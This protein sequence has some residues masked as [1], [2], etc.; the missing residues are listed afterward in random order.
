MKVGGD[1]LSSP[2]N[3]IEKFIIHKD[4][5]VGVIKI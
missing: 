1:D 2:Q 4:K 5:E 3:F